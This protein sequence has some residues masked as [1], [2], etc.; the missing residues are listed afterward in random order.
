[1][2]GSK[3]VEHWTSGTV[4]ECSELAGSP[5]DHELFGNFAKKILKGLHHEIVSS[6]FFFLHWK[7]LPLSLVYAVKPLR[8]E[9]QSCRDSGI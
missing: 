3:R 7:R 5:Q 4:Y 8:M 9:L 1:M 6:V 2:T